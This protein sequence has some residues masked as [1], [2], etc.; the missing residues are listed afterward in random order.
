MY[1]YHNSFS[2]PCPKLDS[3]KLIRWYAYNNFFTGSIP[4]FSTC[5]NNL[6]IVKGAK[7]LFS[8]YTTGFLSGN[9]N[10]YT[11]D[12]S[13]NRLEASMLRPFLIDM[14]ENYLNGGVTKTINFKGQSGPNRLREGSK[15]DG[16]TGEDS[17][18][19]KLKF[20]RGAGWSIL[21]DS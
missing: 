10:A 11:I 12:F 4:D 15:F 7:N 17:T 1:L 9:T 19:A 8:T 18:E 16:T 3:S 21:L 6:R 14:V 2:G 5:G 20:L 13:N